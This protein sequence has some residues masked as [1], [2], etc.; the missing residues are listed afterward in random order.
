[1]TEEITPSTSQEFKESEIEVP[2]ES[3]TM[4]GDD[5]KSY[6]QYLKNKAKMSA[7][8][9]RR[10]QNKEPK[11]KQEPAN[12][13]KVLTDNEKEALL[14]QAY[15]SDTTASNSAK[16]LYDKLKIEGKGSKP[17]ITMR[18]VKLFL[19]RQRRTKLAE[20]VVVPN[21]FNES[22]KNYVNEAITENLHTFKNDFKTDFGSI[23]ED[24]KNQ[25]SK[26]SSTNAQK[27][28][29]KPEEEPPKPQHIQKEITQ[30][31]PQQFTRPAPRYIRSSIGV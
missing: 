3:L 6:Q 10:K 17:P 24:F 28:Q 22:V 15:N 1:M 23:L 2:K 31:I 5:Y 25:F 20:K 8:R 13:S 12:A 14:L 29:P 7:L 21:N 19:G 11:P 9:E 18:E 27:L 4:E 26:S 30:P 16:K